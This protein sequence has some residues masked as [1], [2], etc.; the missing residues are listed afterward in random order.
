M[1]KGYFHPSIHHQK[2][3]NGRWAF[4]KTH[5]IIKTLEVTITTFSLKKNSK[6]RARMK[7]EG[8]RKMPFFNTKNL[9]YQITRNKIKMK[10]SSVPT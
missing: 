5:S 3:L 9:N 1:V 6:L 10:I 4:Q 8:K 2:P 7:R